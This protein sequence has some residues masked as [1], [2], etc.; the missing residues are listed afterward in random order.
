[1]G[2]QQMQEQR[3]Q[4]KQLAQQDARDAERKIDNRRGKQKR[5]GKNSE[6]EVNRVARR[7]HPRN[8]W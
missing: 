1:M 6:K 8:N 2:T 4:L 5:D 3:A 7:S